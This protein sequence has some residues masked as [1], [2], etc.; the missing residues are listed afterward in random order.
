MD[1][2]LV[3]GKD[4]ETG[5]TTNEKDQQKYIAE[6]KKIDRSFE[7]N[8]MRDELFEVRFYIDLFIINIENDHENTC[9]QQTEDLHPVI[10][11]I[12][13]KL[14]LVLISDLK[15]IQNTCKIRMEIAGK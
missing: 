12:Q 14:D 15:F 3:D 4:N 10:D 2:L 13:R 5:K 6:D 7:M 8:D 9:Y 1:L 11:P